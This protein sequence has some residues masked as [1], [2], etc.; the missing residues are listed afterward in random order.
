MSSAQEPFTAIDRPRCS[1]CQTRMMVER[2]TPGPVGF[3]HWLFECPKCDQVEINVTA[4]DPMKSEAAGW[5]VEEIRSP[6]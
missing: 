4:S 5:L 2:V 1:R 3:E 6:T